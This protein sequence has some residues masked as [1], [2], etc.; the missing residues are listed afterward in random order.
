VVLACLRMSG[1]KKRGRSGRWWG[2]SGLCKRRRVR[3]PCIEDASSEA[4]AEGEAAA[5]SQGDPI[6]VEEEEPVAAEKGPS[7]FEQYLRA[8]SLLKS[9]EEWGPF[10]AALSLPLPVTFRVNR[11]LFPAEV[12][13]RCM[14]QAD[15]ILYASG[16]ML[17]FDAGEWVTPAKRIEW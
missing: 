5:P 7:I 16:G 6:Q 8:Q 3:E 1:G 14:Q 10:L 9:E 12:V 17:P 11:G 4:G 13:D 15:A 2:G